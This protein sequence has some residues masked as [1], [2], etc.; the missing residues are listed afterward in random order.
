MWWFQMLK[1]L[2]SVSKVVLVFES[3]FIHDKTSL[4]AESAAASRRVDIK[5]AYTDVDRM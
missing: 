3:A 4:S 2:S 5:G 1:A